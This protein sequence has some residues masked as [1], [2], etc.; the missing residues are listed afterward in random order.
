MSVDLIHNEPR[1]FDNAGF[2]GTE[3]TLELIFI[4]SSK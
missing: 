3:Q 2:L 1:T 4:I